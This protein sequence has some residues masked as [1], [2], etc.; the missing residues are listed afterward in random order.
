MFALETRR[1]SDSAT[2]RVE[3]R[4][5]YD[6]KAEVLRPLRPAEFTGA[7]RGPTIT[8]VGAE[9]GDPDNSSAKPRSMGSALVSSLYSQSAFQYLSAERLGPRKMLP[10]SEEHVRRRSLGSQGEYVLAV[11]ASHGGS[12]IEAGDPRLKDG[13][14]ASTVLAQTT[15]WLQ[16]TSPGSTLEITELRA[17]DAV[18]ARFA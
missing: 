8:V 1:Q 16:E 14:E 2:V 9:G 17:V 10:A 18:S 3:Y 6:R 13:T 5:G 4:F 7:Y 11:L 12:M 15:A